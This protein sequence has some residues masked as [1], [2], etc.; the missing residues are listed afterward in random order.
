MFVDHEEGLVFYDVD[1]GDRSSVHV[2]VLVGKTLT[3]W[4]TFAVAT[5]ETNQQIFLGTLSFKLTYIDNE[6]LNSTNQYFLYEQ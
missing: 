5:H 3:L 1:A 6:N 4:S 2:P